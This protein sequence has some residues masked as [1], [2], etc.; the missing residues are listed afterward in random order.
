MLAVR[1]YDIV[2]WLHISGAI[3]AFGGVVAY[4]VALSVVRTGH[5]RG[6]P[7][8][9]K[10]NEKIT[11]KVM[12]WGMIVVLAAGFY[13]ATDAD[14]WQEPWVSIPLVIIAVLFGIAGGVIT[15]G[16][17]KASA[18]AARDIEASPADGPVTLSAEYEK[19]ARRLRTFAYLATALVL[20]ATFFMTVK[21]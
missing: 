5:E 15:P 10:T 13:L 9:H 7:A 6:L 21:P 12:T 2:L 11:Q 8:F 3:A 14:A 20:V 19:A 17:R 1:F 4:P 18:L 16:E